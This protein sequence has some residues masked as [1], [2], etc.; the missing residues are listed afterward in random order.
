MAHPTEGVVDRVSPC[1]RGLAREWIDQP[2]G[3][4]GTQVSSVAKYISD[5]GI[6]AECVVVLTDGY[7][8]S[9][10]QWDIPTPTLWVVS[11]NKGFTPP[12]GKKI[13]LEK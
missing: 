10:V 5:N 8:E 13:N 6:N 7:V 12:A 1:G 3:G 11:G 4:G 9:S 2:V